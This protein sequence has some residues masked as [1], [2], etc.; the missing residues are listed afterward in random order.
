MVGKTEAIVLNKIKYSDN[1]VIVNFL[2]RDF[3]RFAAI[4]RIPKT[5]KSGI[6]QSLLFPLSIVET[7]I[8]LKDTRTIQSILYCNRTENIDRILYDINKLAIAQFIAEITLK[9]IK[10]EEPNQKV[11]DYLKETIVNLNSS[12][13]NLSGLHIVFLKDFAK[14]SGFGMH[15]NYCEGSPFFNLREG[16]FLPVFTSS[17]ESLDKPESQILAKLLDSKDKEDLSEINYAMRK[18]LIQQILS[19]Y[20][21]HISG[22]GEINSLKVLQ[23]VFA[24]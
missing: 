3:G 22:F 14:L 4:I 1:S 7:E 11:Y 2:S 12:N 18:K 19:Y 15:Q 13:G 8:K 9:T 24:G 21:L 10:E 16:M 5:S 17:E 23:E 6:K 20:K